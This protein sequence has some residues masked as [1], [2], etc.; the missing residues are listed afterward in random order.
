MKTRPLP[1]VLCLLLF[2]VP[3]FQCLAHQGST[4]YL[5]LSVG[6]HQLHGKWEIPVADLD[7]ALKLDADRDRKV[8]PDEM[9][10]RFSE[11]TEF[12]LKHLQLSLDGTNQTLQATNIVPVV[13]TF[14]DG[15]SLIL[16]F[17]ATNLASP[18]TLEVTYRFLFDQKPLDRSFMQVDCRGV[19]QTAVFTADQPTR[20]FNLEVAQ[21]RAEFF[22]YFRHGVWHI[23]IGFD[24]IL[25]LL[26]LLLPS[27]LKREQ[28]QWVPVA[29]F[30]R[31]FINVFQVVTA[32]T[33]AHS[34]TLSLAALKIL[35]LPSR[36]VES[37]IAASVIVA[38]ANNIRSFIPGRIWVVA[39][40]FGLIH[41]FGFA[42]V[43]AELG[44]PRRQ[45]AL[46]LVGFNLGVEAGQLAIVC[47]FLPLAYGL[48][49]TRFYQGAV[50]KLGSALIALLA[51]LWLIERAFDV[52]IF[53]GEEVQAQAIQ[54]GGNIQ[55]VPL[56]SLGRPL[57]ALNTTSDLREGRL[58]A[59]KVCASCHLFPDPHIADRF[60]WANTILPRMNPWL[61]Y[62]AV[63]WTN[64][65]GGMEVIGSGKVPTA[66]ILDWAALRAIHNYYLESAPLQPLPQPEKPALGSKLK[67]FRVHESTY[68]SADPL[69]ALVKI[70]E[71]ARSIF[72]SDGG[73]KK[74]AVLRP[75][76]T[77]ATLLEMPNPIVHLLERTNG[78]YAT[79]IGSIAP[80]D[81][82]EGRLVGIETGSTNSATPFKRTQTILPGLCRPVE[83][84]VA[85]LNQ[86]G[87]ED[88]IVANFG[89]ILGR[90][91]WFQKK[92]TGAYE[93]H[94]LLDRAGATSVKAR[95]FNGDGR[96]DIVVLMAQGQEGIY[97]FL[98]LGRGKF[99]EKLVA[100]K[101]PAWGFTHLEVVDMNRDGKTD[102]LVSNGDNGDTILFP[103]SLKP[104]HG[105]R[106][107]LNEGAGNFREAWFYPMHGAYRAVARDFDLDG[108]ID[109]AA[110]AY[111]P[112]Y[113]GPKA[114]S[115]ALLENLGGM[116]F[117]AF[118]FPESMAGRWITLDAGDLDGDGDADIVLGA[119][120]RSFG[121]LP[122]QLAKQWAD[123]K[124]TTL[125]LQNTVR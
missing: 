71:R 107:Y 96:V 63:N 118:S 108:D 86:D 42:S 77:P 28:N 70:D 31:A 34:I 90:F 105:V 12:A 99:E 61:G 32:F 7:L 43:L 80:S 57:A 113:F 109:L 19:T 18:R 67:H 4:S 116:R 25:F 55:A 81:L 53:P 119:S 33:I 79:L 36:W 37:A 2:L 98:N 82:A 10:K 64:E 84:A 13:E 106:I 35:T 78:F 52:H 89:N 14:P 101:H 123:K 40:V 115:F 97:L 47:L 9:R 20:R 44:L 6:D 27:V 65:P 102:L 54:P 83:S 11:V 3:S 75:D 111:F 73:S 29:T 88:L 21:P 46:A 48:R 23:W 72:V 41:G 93:E 5:T 49:R 22:S 24:H 125:I 66:P 94:I 60:S 38:A 1:G 16:G 120:N 45:L 104:Y 110:I 100:Q 85:D 17:V 69:I 51:G 8:S 122:A 56:N 74:L 112:D 76:G 87:R 124:I 50:L 91:S 117:A 15:A 30:R 58:L 121:D 39:F 92:E 68:R 95:D 103:N 62:D 114:Q 26:A 59:E